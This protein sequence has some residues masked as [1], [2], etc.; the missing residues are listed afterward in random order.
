M[1]GAGE[2]STL[3]LSD[4]GAS[5][6]AFIVD[7]ESI[8]TLRQGLQSLGD[9]DLRRGSVRQ[10]IKHLE[11]ERPPH[12]VIV[13]IS[14]A[15]NAQAVL[16][17]LARVC[18]PDVQVF[19]VG[20]NTD[21]TFYRRLVDDLGVSEYL[22]K[23]LT[24]DAVQRQLLHRLRPDAIN[25]G[26]PRGGQLI[27]MCGARGGVGTTSIAVGLAMELASVAKGHVAL[28]DLH[29]QGGA[30]A[31]MLGGTPG[32]GLRM[33][34]EDGERADSLFLERTAITVAPRLQMIVADEPMEAV[35][36]VTE[37]GVARLIA[38]LQRKFNYVVVDMPVPVPPAMHPVMRAARH[39]VVVATP[40]V[41][42]L[43]DARAL[44]NWAAATGGP[45]RTLLVLNHA[46]AK[47]GLGAK[48]IEKALGQKP[49]ILIP[50]LGRKMMDAVNLGVPATKHVPALRRHLHALVRE[51]G[52]VSPARAGG[53]ILKRMFGG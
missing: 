23:P 27:A 16:D 15:D 33:A 11:T 32:A 35:L 10:A 42:A 28:L 53:S 1:S 50:G 34:L 36:K 29:L 19:V 31:L 21:I 7:N 3:N 18:P 48:L 40:D 51:V 26:A 49:D 17:D 47:G 25:P 12:A 24:R 41:V 43:R 37:A 5:V 13:D 2:I 14:G 52:G 44:R 20:D 45:N 30:V 4:A 38:L 9:V 8:E 46:D 22:P 6:L 39:V